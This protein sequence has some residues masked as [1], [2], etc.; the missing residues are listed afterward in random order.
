[1]V[2]MITGN[3]ADFIGFTLIQG[4][5]GVKMTD[6]NPDILIFRDING[7]E[8]YG[9]QSLAKR[10]DRI[11]MIEIINLTIWL[12]YFIIKKETILKMLLRLLK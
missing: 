11:E 5:N 12:T 7:K 8:Y 9:S 2:G 6:N 1:M 3:F 4:L 10:L